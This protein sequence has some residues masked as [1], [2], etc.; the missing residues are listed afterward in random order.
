MW[1]RLRRSLLYRG[2]PVE[3][4]SRWDEAAGLRYHA[5]VGGEGP[6]VV[7]VHGL[8]V[9]GRYLLPT[10]GRLAQHCTVYVPDLPGFGRTGDPPRALDVPGLAAALAAW[11][12]AVGVG[13]ATFLGNSMGCQYIADLAAREPERV[14]GALLVGPTMD[15]AA[16]SLARQS[17][18]LI[19][20]VLREPPALLAIVGVDYLIAGPRRVLAT[21]RAGVADPI[22]DKAERV[23]ARVLVVRGERDPIVPQRWAEE[24][25]AR[26]P[27]GHLAVVAGA[28]HAVNYAAPD[29]LARLT[30][31]FLAAG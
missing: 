10:A 17:G 31:D 27:D 5:R 14:E 13:R 15:A 8:G 20:D 24:L 3:L 11:L 4:E 26:F 2:A 30:L 19:A 29:E 18:R 23:V 16:R 28:P 22:E 21:A 9:S 6:P 7:L 12:D 25:A 1:A